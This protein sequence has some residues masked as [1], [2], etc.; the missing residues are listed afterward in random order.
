MTHTISF[1][2]SQATAL[3]DRV[4]V[5]TGKPGVECTAGAP[6]SPCSGFNKFLKG[7]NVTFR[8]DPENGRPRINKRNSTLDREQKR[9]GNYYTL[10]EA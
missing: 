1:P 5:Y 3:Y 7:L 2:P 6:E 4:I 10:E 8:R 9:S